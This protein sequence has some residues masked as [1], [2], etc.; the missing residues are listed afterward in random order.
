MTTFRLKNQKTQTIRLVRVS[1]PMHIKTENQKR[2]YIFSENLTFKNYNKI[3][4]SITT[5]PGIILVFKQENKKLTLYKKIVSI[6]NLRQDTRNILSFNNS[7][8]P[9]L[10]SNPHTQFIIQYAFVHTE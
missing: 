10:L 8:L 7:I 1:D 5:R 6:E 2:K 4:E 3:I 9:Q